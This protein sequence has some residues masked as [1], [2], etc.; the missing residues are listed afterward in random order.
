VDPL[1]SSLL[2]QHRFDGNVRELRHLMQQAVMVIGTG[3]L[4][5][6]TLDA[7]PGWWRTDVLTADTAA[8][9]ADASANAD[10]TGVSQTS[11]ALAEQL[12]RQW[13]DTG[14]GYEDISQRACGIAIRVAMADCEQ[15]ITRAA[16]RLQITPR[17]IHKRR[18]K[19]LPV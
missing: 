1:V 12:V 5:P 8:D 2:Q 14:L 6:L 4:S 15:N 11:T 17:T 10:A 13:I 18:E 3:S 16:Q 19:G 7:L 9:L